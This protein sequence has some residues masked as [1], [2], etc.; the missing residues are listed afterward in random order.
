MAEVKTLPLNNLATPESTLRRCLEAEESA[1]FERVLV[2]W[3]DKQGNCGY[4]CSKQN[5]MQTL[6]DLERTKA[7]IMKH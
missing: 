6:W 4:S 5:L 3:T 1:G 7:L 2:I